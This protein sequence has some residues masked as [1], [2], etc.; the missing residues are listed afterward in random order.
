MSL[1]GFANDAQQ[2]RVFIPPVKKLPPNPHIGHGSAALLRALAPPSETA[3]TD[4]EWSHESPEDKSLRHRLLACDQ[5][6]FFT[7][8]ASADLQAA[9]IINAVRMNP[10]RKK[11]VEDLLSQQKLQDPSVYKFLLDSPTNAILLEATLHVHWDLYGTFCIVPSDS[12]ASAMLE[13]LRKI[14][15]DWAKHDASEGHVRPL[16][17]SKP[18]FS[19]PHWE[20]VVLHPHALLPDRQPLVIAQDRTLYRQGEAALPMSSI[21]WTYWIAVEDHLC[22]A[23]PPH[24]PL[25]PFIVPNVRSAYDKPLLSSLAIVINAHYKLDQFMRDHGSSASPRVQRFAQQMSDLVTAIFFVPQTNSG[26]TVHRQQGYHTTEVI[27]SQ[28][29]LVAHRFSAPGR[30]LGQESPSGTM[31]D[32][33]EPPGEDLDA[34]EPPETPDADGL[35]ASEF[36]LVA[37]RAKDPLL[38]P[39]QRA[40]A[41]MTM[42]FGTRRYEDPYMSAQAVHS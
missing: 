7:G 30:P 12:D 24:A 5:R 33:S 15:E 10:E 21:T 16:D 31:E 26:V 11:L 35:T 39:K 34:V 40:V 27:P 32:N 17:I 20:I 25:D 19:R 13:A 29:S 38:D 6:S 3:G 18:P 23:S 42:I 9:H 41:A 14:N 36:R 8:S 37:A 4:S 1:L 22:S 2:V 28:S